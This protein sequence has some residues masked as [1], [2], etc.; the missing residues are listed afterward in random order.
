MKKEYDFSNSVKNPY[1]KKLKHQITIRIED[2]TIKYFKELASE[3]DIPYQKLINMFLREC[4]RK[5][6]RPDISWKTA[7]QP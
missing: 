7:A 6:L 5:E 2:E 4:A 3:T 1:V